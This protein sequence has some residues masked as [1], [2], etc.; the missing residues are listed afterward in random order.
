M[1]NNKK[2]E[3]SYTVENDIDGWSFRTEATYHPGKCQERVRG[4]M[5]TEERAEAMAEAAGNIIAD[6][7]LSEPVVRVGVAAWIYKDGKVLMGKRKGSH[8]AGS[9]SLPGGHVD[10]GETPATTVAREIMEETGLEVGAITHCTD[11]PYGHRF[12]PEDNKQY[13]TLFFNAEYIGGEPV[14]AEPDKCEG[15]EW[16]IL[17]ALPSPL[18]GALDD[19]NMIN[20]IVEANA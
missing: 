5:E 18:F 15:W 14:N 12:F 13:I 10:F 4:I 20:Q 8:G 17:G 2:P 1:T 19:E 6:R 16:F 9:W 3:P 7:P 11:F